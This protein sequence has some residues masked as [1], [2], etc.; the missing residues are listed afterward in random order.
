VRIEITLDDHPIDYDDPR[1]WAAHVDVFREASGEP[2]D[3]VFTSEPYGDELGRRLGARH[4]PVDPSR[5]HVPVSGRALRRDL[6]AH[7]EFL[8]PAV[9]SY[10]ARRVVVL[11]AE[12]T[13]TTT[14][15]RSLAEHFRST[16]APEIGWQVSEQKLLD[17]TFDRWE[18]REFSSIAAQQRQALEEAARSGGP[19]VFS[20]TDALATCV[21][22]E[23][24]L[25]ASSD[26]TEQIAAVMQSDLYLL[27]VDDG[28]PFASHPLRDGEDVRPWMTARFRERLAAQSAPWVELN[29]T[30]DERLA[31]AVREVERLLHA[32][33]RFAPT[34]EEGAAGYSSTK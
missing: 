23:R 5:E 13:G 1:V 25:G 31:K 27:T 15:T 34:L 4:E 32:G 8:S 7:W 21:W 16:W 33:W 9:R 10:F 12:S 29:G 26:E 2:I 24:Y 14:I 19:V 6:A 28:V 18:P 17:G 30:R 11:G 3:V 22:E 20:D